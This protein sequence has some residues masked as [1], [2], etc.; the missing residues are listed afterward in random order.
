[1]DPEQLEHDWIHISSSVNVWETS[2]NA[3]TIESVDLSVCVFICNGR[4]IHK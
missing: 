2:I 4:F 3:N 1:M